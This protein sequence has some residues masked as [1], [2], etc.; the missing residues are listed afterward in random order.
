MGMFPG[1]ILGV[2]GL[3]DLAL[4]GLAWLGSAQLDSTY[5]IVGIYGICNYSRR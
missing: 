2:V 4:L 3:A 1:M 5:G